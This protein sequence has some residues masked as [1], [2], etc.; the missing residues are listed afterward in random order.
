VRAQDLADADAL[1]AKL[2]RVRARKR[3]EL[4]DVDG[5]EGE[6]LGR[7]E[8]LDRWIAAVR[9]AAPL[10]TNDLAAWVAGG[11]AVF[12]GAQGVLLDEEAGFAPHVTHACTTFAPA[13][14]LATALG[15]RL[16][17]VGVLRAHAVRHG[18]GPLPTEDPRI[19]PRLDHNRENQW[20]GAVR[21]GAFDAVLARY[22]LA[23]AGPVD[24]LVLTHLDGP[25]E[26]LST[27]WEGD[28]PVT[29]ASAFG[30]RPI[31]SRTR[32][33]AAE[34]SHLLG[35]PVVATSTGPRAAD[36]AWE[37]EP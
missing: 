20:Q 28:P 3:E 11:P 32:D 25:C 14:R 7:D 9:D 15:L 5:D 27:A 26:T 24:G 37:R 18:A 30:A 13:E 31:L 19:R 23:V 21:Y 6:I 34:V 17:R 10:V 12:E 2:S 8:V 22:A 29:T 4:G 1:R 16:R 35:V 33:F 36:L